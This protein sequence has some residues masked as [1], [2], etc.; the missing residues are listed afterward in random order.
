MIIVMSTSRQE[1]VDH[2]VARVEEFGYKPHVIY[3]VER[4][5]VAA[6]GDERGKER[7]TSLESLPY[8][9]QVI[10]ILKPF[11][12]A[13]REVKQENTVIECAGVLIGGNHF[14]L[15]AGPCSVESEEQIM[16][17]AR[18]AKEAG[19]NILRGGAF[20]P[21][22]SP[23]SFQGMEMEG[24]RALRKAAD[25]YH[26]PF[27]TEATTPEQIPVVAQYADMIQIG[28][29]NMQNYG[30]LRAA[31]KAGK[32]VLLKRGMMSTINEFLMSAEYILSEGN[33]HVILCER[34]IRTFETET[35]NTLD[36][37]AVP[38]V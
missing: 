28:A 3:G 26:M 9:E 2:V 21:R 33:P 19:A 34:G 8:V 24:L 1:D 27:V 10:R 14:A 25:A 37:Q 15:M 20:K 29:R 11:K 7:L 22:T 6:V 5:V 31:G 12:L 18:I 16:E 35:R 17:S 32:P 30:L 13:G 4:T 38:V 36:I 23:Y